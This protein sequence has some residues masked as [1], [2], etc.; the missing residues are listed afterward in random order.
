MLRYP[1][2]RGLFDLVEIEETSARRVMLRL[3]GLLAKVTVSVIG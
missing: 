1:A 3:L 2:S